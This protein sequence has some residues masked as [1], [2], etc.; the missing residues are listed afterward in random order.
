MELWVST[1]PEEKGSG[2]SMGNLGVYTLSGLTNDVTYFLRLVPIGLDGLSVGPITPP[3]PV[4]PRADPDAPNG[5]IWING[6]APSTASKDVVLTLIASDVPLDG[7]SSGASGAVSNRWT[8]ALNEISGDIE[9]RISN[10]ASF[11]GVPWEPYSFNKDWIL[12][13]SDSDTYQV[14]AQF[15]DAAGN[16]SIVVWDQIRYGNKVYLPIV[17]R[18]R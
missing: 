10:D 9:M 5:W 2:R 14:Y 12:G 18:N 8:R 11:A 15:R 1:D 17:L 7:P 4:M 16:N 6:N 13:D 3:H